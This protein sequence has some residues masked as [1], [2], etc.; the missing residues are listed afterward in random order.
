MA[1]DLARLF[2]L[3]GSPFQRGIHREDN[4]D[5]RVRGMRVTRCPDRRSATRAGGMFSKPGNETAAAED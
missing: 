4:V 5:Q 2:T 3:L 1:V